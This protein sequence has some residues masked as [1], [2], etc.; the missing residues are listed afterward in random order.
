[1]YGL[2]AGVKGLGFR[3]QRSELGVSGLG[4]GVKGLGF[5]A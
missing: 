4:S 1:M 5:R 3:V 2:G